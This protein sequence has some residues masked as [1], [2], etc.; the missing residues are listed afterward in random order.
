AYLAPVLDHPGVVFGDDRLALVLAHA[1]QAHL[2][3]PLEVRARHARAREQ[4]VDLDQGH[5][6]VGRRKQPAPEPPAHLVEEDALARA[7][8]VLLLIEQR[9]DGLE[10]QKALVLQATNE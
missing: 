3:E 6:F 4:L 8:R 9:A 5:P 2:R 1:E 7:E 10:R